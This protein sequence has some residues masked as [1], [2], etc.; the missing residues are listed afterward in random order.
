M[1]LNYANKFLDYTNMCR[2]NI[3]VQFNSRI[4]EVAKENE[5]L[6]E[7]KIKEIINKEL[8]EDLIDKGKKR[9]C[10]FNWEDS[11]NKIWR[12]IKK[13]ECHEDHTL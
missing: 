11:A 12:I 5:F 9:V 8:C 10:D 1:F 13:V 6:S 2:I 4:M 3:K 7:L